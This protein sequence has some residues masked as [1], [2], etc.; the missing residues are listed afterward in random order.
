MP[1]TSSRCPPRGLR[2]RPVAPSRCSTRSSISVDRASHRPSFVPAGG[3][4]RGSRGW[5]TP[6]PPPRRAEPAAST[7]VAP[8]IG[9]WAANGSEGPRRPPPGP[10][11][12]RRRICPPVRSGNGRRPEVRHYADGSCE[13]RAPGIRLRIR[14]CDGLRGEGREE[15]HRG[16]V[17]GQGGDQR[18]HEDGPMLPAKLLRSRAH[19]HD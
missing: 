12:R 14:D 5:A 17:D 6:A 15:E 2:I 1:P 8:G 11:R 9:R 13:D 10:R 7:P 16:A 19:A 18:P 4:R 3:L